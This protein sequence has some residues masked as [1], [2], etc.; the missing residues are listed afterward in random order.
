[1]DDIF[2]RCAI[3][4]IDDRFYDDLQS[5]QPLPIEYLEAMDSYRNDSNEYCIDNY[6]IVRNSPSDSPSITENKHQDNSN[7]PLTCSN[8]QSTAHM[9]NAT[10]QFEESKQFIYNDIQHDSYDM[11][12]NDCKYQS[13]LDTDIH[14]PCDNINLSSSSIRPGRSNKNEIH[15]NDT[16]DNL[17]LLQRN[18]YDMLNAYNSDSIKYTNNDIMKDTSNVSKYADIDNNKF[19][20]LDYNEK[21]VDNLNYEKNYHYRGE[22]L[23]SVRYIKI[24]NYI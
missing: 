23:Y 18:T 10:M 8:D 11:I 1:M 21:E 14:F 6:N 2:E 7:Y 4:K 16:N 17:V 9:N 3:R 12:Q 20:I 15:N 24:C 19:R 5:Y 22:E 13:S